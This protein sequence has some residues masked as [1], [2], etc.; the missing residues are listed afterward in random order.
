MRCILQGNT[1]RLDSVILFSLVT[2]GLPV[3]MHTTSC[4]VYS[5]SYVSFRQRWSLESRFIA[6]G[7]IWTTACKIIRLLQCRQGRQLALER[8]EKSGTTV[9]RAFLS[10]I[11][12]YIYA[13]HYS[14]LRVNCT[15][16]FSFEFMTN[17]FALLK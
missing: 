8:P 9:L 5:R 7:S 3:T 12:E 16:G 10:A 15:S 13:M 17:D 6:V 4:I 1:L 14:S 2:V 11:H